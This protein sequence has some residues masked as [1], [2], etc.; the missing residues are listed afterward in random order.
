MSQIHYA[1]YWYYSNSFNSG[2]Q[3]IT[4]NFMSIYIILFVCYRH[5]IL[6]QYLTINRISP[7]DSFKFFCL[8]KKKYFNLNESINF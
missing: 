6:N 1:I 7:N 3:Y 2:T 5:L 8:K 4:E